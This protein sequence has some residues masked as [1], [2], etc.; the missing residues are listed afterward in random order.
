M[1][2]APYWKVYTADGEYIASTK[3]PFYAAMILAGIG[4][5]GTTIRAGH[6]KKFTVY[7]DFVDGDA[8]NSYDEV[9]EICWSKEGTNYGV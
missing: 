3:H 1:A 6:N 4:A 8:S 5:K 9:A 2:K 7:A